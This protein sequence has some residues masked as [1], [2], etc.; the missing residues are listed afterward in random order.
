MID[1]S[2]RV[3]DEVPPKVRV[4]VSEMV[5][6]AR[7]AQAVIEEH[8]QAETD[9]LVRAVAWAIH[10]PDRAEELARIAVATTGFGN[11]ADKINKNQRKTKGTL[12]D[13][14]ADRSVGI[15]RDDVESG[16]TEYA[17]PVGVVGAVVPST[18]P[19]ATPANNAM[20]ALKA[21]NAIIISPSPKGVSSCARLVEFIHQ[22]LAKVGAPADLIQYIAQPSKAAAFELMRQV[23]LVVVTGSL[24]NVR[25][26]YAS[27]TP[28][29]GVGQGNAAVVVDETA[30]LIQAAIKIRRSKT[31]DYGTS[32]SSENSV[33]IHESV[34]DQALDAL[35]AEGGYLLTQEEKERLASVMWQTGRLNAHL[36]AQAPDVIAVKADLDQPEARQARFFMVAEDGVGPDHPFSGEK[37]SVVLAVYKYQDFD[38]ALD[39]IQKIYDY[40]GA[41]HSAGI[42]TTDEDR[43]RYMAERLKVARVLVNQAHSFGNGGA[44]DNGLNFTLTMGAGTWAGNSFSDNLSYRHFMNI[45]RLVRTIPSREPSDADL[46]GEYWKRFG[47]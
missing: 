19:V 47:R 4:A 43:A 22:E 1:Q 3:S 23:D 27:G 17:K 10:R 32:C 45:T 42:H 41:G 35:S 2:L 39:R 16:I 34:Y 21:R 30:D 28:A 13:L 5:K 26:A 18:N 12:R 31:F 37:L 25:A 6:R 9:D 20:M 11:V 40:Q 15:I 29:L 7:C 8:N 44:F 36:I 38:A 24:K 46:F 33:H 14:L